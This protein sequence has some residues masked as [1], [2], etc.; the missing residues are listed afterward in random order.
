MDEV[1]KIAK[2]RA[3][4]DSHKGAE[5]ENKICNDAM[6]IFDSEC[7]DALEGE[8]CQDCIEEDAELGKEIIKTQEVSIEE[9]AIMRM[10][11]AVLI[12]ALEQAEESE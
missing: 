11:N 9:S 3:E 7:S 1:D 4:K 2:E 8:Y 6:K 10:R 5:E 12:E